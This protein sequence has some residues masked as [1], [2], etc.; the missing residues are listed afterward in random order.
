MLVRQGGNSMAYLIIGLLC[1]FLPQ[2]YM[3][4]TLWGDKINVLENQDTLSLPPIH[5]DLPQYH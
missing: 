3:L 1:V 4:G 2:D 5:H